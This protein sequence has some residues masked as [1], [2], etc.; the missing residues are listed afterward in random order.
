[1]CPMLMSS[2]YYNPLVFSHVFTTSG[3]GKI[4]LIGESFTA[5]KK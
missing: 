3:N 1:M 2:A 5:N 4:F